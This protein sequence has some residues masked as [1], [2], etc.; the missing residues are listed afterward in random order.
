VELWRVDSVCLGNE[1]GNE[2]DRLSQ[3]FQNSSFGPISEVVWYESWDPSHL[4]FEQ[5]L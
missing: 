3:I 2:T 4:Q 1:V 5:T